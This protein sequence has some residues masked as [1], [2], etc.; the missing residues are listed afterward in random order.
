M[1]SQF[2]NQEPDP[3]DPKSY[4]V[5]K[6]NKE[7]KPVYSSLPKQ[8]NGMLKANDIPV[9]NQEPDPK[10][11]KSYIVPKPNKE[12]KPVYSSLPKQTG[13]IKHIHK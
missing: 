7:T 12:T 2:S 6:P 1:I 3:K 9:L 10:D 5:P 13:Y 4:I 11:P 8:V